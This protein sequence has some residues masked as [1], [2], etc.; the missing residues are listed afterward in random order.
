MPLHT[1]LI[2]DDVAT[3]STVALEL[4]MHCPDEVCI[5][6]ACS[7]AAEGLQAIR[8]L[9]PDL[10]ILDIEMPKYSGM[11]IVEML[12]AEGHHHF[13]VIFTT[14]HEAFSIQAFAVNALHYLLKPYHADE[15][16]EAIR[17]AKDKRASTAVTVEQVQTLIQQA[18]KRPKIRIS[19]SEGVTFLPIEQIV[20]VQADGGYAVIQLC[21]GERKLVSIPL[22]AIE[23]QLLVL[24]NVFKRTHQ[25]YLVNFD[26]V[27]G[28]TPDG[29]ILLNGL[30]IEIPVSRPYKSLHHLNTI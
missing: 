30:K 4:N 10:V 16:K 6:K 14:A 3:L 18:Q 20:F 9:K 23:S 26:F 27:K 25:S 2:D 15:L 17:R 13:E 19:T 28:F 11:Q 22:K 24:S 12:R 21:N 8:S 1:I 5:L 29:S 7:D